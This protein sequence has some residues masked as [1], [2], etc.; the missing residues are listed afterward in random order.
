M[1]RVKICGHKSVDDIVFSVEA[2]AHAVGVIYGFPSS[3]RNNGLGEASKLLEKVPSLTERVLVTNALG[4]GVA[5]KLGVKTVQLVAEPQQLP[6][7]KTSY[8]SLRLIPVL[9]I[10]R[11]FPQP[12]IIK[13][14]SDFDV[15]LLD[16]KIGSRAGGTGKSHDWSVSRRLAKELGRVVLAGGL[17]P[18]NLEEAVCMVEPYAV[19]VSSGVE[20]SPG[21]K[22]HRL[23][24]AFVR[25][26]MEIG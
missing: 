8:P 24:K 5:D 6:R 23:V 18:G 4:L 17:N 22:D 15:V 19:D 25:R 1:V 13:I 11:K 10:E 16:T 26:A 21:V 2:G 20:S 3:P 9:Y 12:E 7:L 14:F